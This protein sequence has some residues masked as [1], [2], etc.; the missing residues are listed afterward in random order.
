MVKAVT[1]KAFLNWKFLCLLEQLWVDDSSGVL[2]LSVHASPQA[3]ACLCQ[4]LHTSVLLPPT[5]LHALLEV[6]KMAADLGVHDL[7]NPLQ[8]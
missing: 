6:C 1:F 8:F 4:Y 7:P 5:T 3:L 2:E